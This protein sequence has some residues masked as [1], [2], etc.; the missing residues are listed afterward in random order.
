MVFVLFEEGFSVNKQQ[1]DFIKEG[2]IKAT[3][4]CEFQIAF[5]LGRNA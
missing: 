3:F 2:L 5:V 4:P 1:D